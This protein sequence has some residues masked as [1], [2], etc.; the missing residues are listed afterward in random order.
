M[1]G[2]PLVLIVVALAS[3]ASR[4]GSPPARE[5]DRK[6]A[7]AIASGDQGALGRVYDRY[8]RLVFSLA[9]RILADHTAAEEVAQDVFL[10][11]WH[12]AGDFDPARGDLVSWL[13]TVTRNRAID[14]LRSRQQREARTWIPMPESP[15]SIAWLAT[16]PVAAR[17][18]DAERV[19]KVLAS[20]P[21]QQRR[22]IEL[23]YYEGYSQAE[24]AA[25]LEL[26][27]GTVKTW[28]RTALGALREVIAS[29]SPR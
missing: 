8:H 17:F 27:L 15:D 11:L 6:E 18:D 16:P 10:R 2:D 28:T 14:Q 3:A 4:S 26:P 19:G 1:S 12:R 29:G 23:A 24:I 21:E 9:L 5:L 13:V 20:L 25:L 22:M 7:A